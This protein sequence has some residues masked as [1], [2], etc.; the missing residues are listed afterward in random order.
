MDNKTFQ[1]IKKRSLTL[2]ESSR[3]P[4]HGGPHLVRVDQNAQRIVKILKIH[5]QIDLNILRSICY[6][7]DLA[8]SKHKPGVVNHIREGKRVKSIVTK[9][10]K[11]IGTP[12]T[13]KKIIITA[14]WKH[15]FSFPWRRLNK[16][17]DNYA[18][19]LQ[20]AD[21]LDEFSIE[22][23]E[24]LVDSAKQYVFYKILKKFGSKTIPWV[25]RNVRY[26][27]NYPEL[28]KEFYQ[29]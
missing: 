1:E 26:F 6:L 21:T 3:D 12:D 8:Y 18:K 4:Q 14:V 2:M 11:D 5:N 17:E 7:H 10:L 9:L 24:S 20:D 28:A 25:R 16:K 23:L 13:E 22:R 19:I 29:E 27:L 15:T